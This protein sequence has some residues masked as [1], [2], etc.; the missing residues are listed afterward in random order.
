VIRVCEA[1]KVKAVVTLKSSQDD[2]EYDLCPE[3]FEAV[4]LIVSGAFF[5]D[6]AAENAPKRGR[7]PKAKEATT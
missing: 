3:C 4:Q 5:A 7:P 6:A 2:S 1:H